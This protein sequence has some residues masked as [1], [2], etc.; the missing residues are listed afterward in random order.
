MGLARS[1][2]GWWRPWVLAAAVALP[3]ALLATL[4][5]A[6]VSPYLEHAY[7]VVARVLFRATGWTGTPLTP[8]IGLPLLLV[9]LA[10]AV[11]AG[12]RQGL[13]LV[14]RLGRVALL[15]AVTFSWFY[16]AWGVNYRRPPVEQLLGLPAERVGVEEL[17]DL[18]DYLLRAVR[19]GVA[20][21]EEAA[22]APGGRVGA[23]FASVAAE[24]DGLVARLGSP[25]RVPAHL[26]T[27]PPGT[28][29]TFG[30]A[31]MISPFLLEANVDGALTDHARVAV[32][33]H[34]L[35]HLAG[36]AGEA[37][38]D[39][40]GAIAGLRAADPYARYSVALD[41]LARLTW[42][43][44]PKVLGRVLAELPE[45]AQ[46]D[47]RAAAEVRERHYRPAASR[48]VTAAYDRY[49]RTQ[50]VEAGVVDYERGVRLLA[51]ALRAGE[52]D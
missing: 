16:L 39:L 11:S 37:D 50:G 13:G 38:A 22:A 44:P 33:A 8:L 25:V 24:L 28:L 4:P 30:Y 29:M 35:A 52:I 7:P 10:W 23:A 49:L 36:F 20:A 41:Q 43:L 42:H 51:L 17:S 31:G 6:W 15:A 2:A 34:E 12:G 48:T 21:A 3:A 47:L 5:L 40:V 46:A 26:K 19:Q 14:A 45:R 9:G 18:A 27:L 32:G 1:A